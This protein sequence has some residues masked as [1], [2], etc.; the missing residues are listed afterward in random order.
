MSPTVTDYSYNSNKDTSEFKININNIENP[1]GIEYTVTGTTVT[2]DTNI[3]P[4]RN[5]SKKYSDF[6]LY[7][8]DIEYKILN[9]TLPN[10]KTDTDNGIY[11]VVQGNPFDHCSDLKNIINEFDF[12]KS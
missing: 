9:V 10:S 6:V 8:N 1:F 2:D 3:T 5:F 7:Y 4:L 12:K 11:L